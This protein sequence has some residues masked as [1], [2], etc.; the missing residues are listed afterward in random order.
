MA[1]MEQ[2]KVNEKAAEKVPERALSPKKPVIQPQSVSS[3]KNKT[4]KQTA[5]LPKITNDKINFTQT[6]IKPKNNMIDAETQTYKT[7]N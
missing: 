6:S 1:Q 2:K 4:L 3:A 5:K 7:P